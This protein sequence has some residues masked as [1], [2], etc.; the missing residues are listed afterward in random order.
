[1]R[2]TSLCI[3]AIETERERESSKKQNDREEGVGGVGEGQLGADN[4]T[5]IQ[6]LDI[7]C[8]VCSVCELVSAGGGG[9]MIPINSRDPTDLAAYKPCKACKP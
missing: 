7:S 6:P 1:M 2:L 3:Y 5:A 9:G 8:S 4:L